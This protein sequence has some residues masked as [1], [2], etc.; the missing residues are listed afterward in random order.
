VEQAGK[1]MLRTRISFWGQ[2][3]LAIQTDSIELDLPEPYTTNHAIKEVADSF[4]PLKD[5][6]LDDDQVRASILVFANGIQVH[7][8]DDGVLTD[9]MEL[10]LM[11]PIAGG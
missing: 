10:T 5:L 4:P 11:S 8:G 7:E 9:G 6:L 1:T 3:K 2:L